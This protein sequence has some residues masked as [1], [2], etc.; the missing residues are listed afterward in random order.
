MKPVQALCRVVLDGYFK[1]IFALNEQMN[2]ME[3]QEDAVLQFDVLENF[4][5]SFVHPMPSYIK[6]GTFEWIAE[7]I[8][9]CHPA[10]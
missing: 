2:E 9:C 7:G 6:A 10:E 3:D 5:E 8:R 1:M 4:K